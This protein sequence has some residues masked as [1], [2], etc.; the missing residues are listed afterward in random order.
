MKNFT[1][2]V[3]SHPDLEIEIVTDKKGNDIY[4]GTSKRYEPFEATAETAMD[5][6]FSFNI[7]LS[8]QKVIAALLK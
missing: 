2:K 6:F 3:L 1:R 7:Q 4:A 5:C 8:E